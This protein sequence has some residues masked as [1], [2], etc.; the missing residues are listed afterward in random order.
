MK[1]STFIVTCTGTA[2]VLLASS[3]HAKSPFDPQTV[4]LEPKPTLIIEALN[5]LRSGNPDAGGPHSMLLGTLMYRPMPIQF[6]N[7]RPE[8]ITAEPNYQGTVSYGTIPLGDAANA[9][10][11]L[12]LEKREGGNSRI[13]FDK[14]N[15]GDL[16]DDGDGTWTHIKKPEDAPHSFTLDAIAQASYSEAERTSP[17]GVRV[18]YRDGDERASYHRIGARVGTVTIDGSELPVTLVDQT[19]RGNYATGFDLDGGYEPTREEGGLQIFFGNSSYDACGTFLYNDVNYLARTSAD[20]MTLVIE[21]TPRMIPSIAQQRAA[22]EKAA[23]ESKRRILQPG[24]EIPAFSAVMHNG[25]PLDLSAYT[26]DKIV[27]L[28]LWASW[29]GPCKV[30]LKHIDELA[31]IV[32]PEEVVFIALNVQDSSRG[33]EAFVNANENVS[34]MF[35]RDPIGRDDDSVARNVFGVRGIPATFVIDRDGTISATIEGATKDDKRIDQALK[36]LGVSIPERS[37]A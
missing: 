33:Y 25:D 10:H 21:P 35:A 5:G 20:G 22:E 26:G 30:G 34:Y 14:N 31:S 32:D 6:T 8:S 17:V 3:L 37:G 12:A 15:N 13:F 23:E 7:D 24:Q 36:E 9:A 16:T 1:L 18:Y 27:V 11:V 19:S 29:C 2:V 28:D 4:E